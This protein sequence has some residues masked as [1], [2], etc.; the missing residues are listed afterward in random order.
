MLKSMRQPFDPR[1]EFVAR[2][3]F[4]C[5]GHKFSSGGDFP[6][7]RL[8]LDN[9]KLYRLWEHKFIDIKGDDRPT[10]TVEEVEELVESE[11]IVETDE[12]SEI[13][14]EIEDNE[15]GLLFDPEVHTLAHPSAGQ[16]L[17]MCG[18]EIVLHVERKEWKRLE[19]KTKPARVNMDR[20]IS[21]D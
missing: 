2:R 14:G 1:G 4:T 10:E 15:E 12:A 17:I 6:W 5:N 8:S 19:K 3:S 7:K 16:W 18:G 20:V 21:E 9:R 11:E 13:D